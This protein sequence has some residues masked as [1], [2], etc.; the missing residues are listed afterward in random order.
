MQ[1]KLIAMI[2]DKD[3][4]IR[5]Q[6]AFEISIETELNEPGA[7]LVCGSRLGIEIERELIA[8]LESEQA[9]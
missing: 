8:P 3:S 9:L 1:T 7:Q 2:A 4:S 6:P 5:G